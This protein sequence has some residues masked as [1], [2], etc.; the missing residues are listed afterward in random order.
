MKLGESQNKKKITPWDVKSSKIILEDRWIKVRVDE[1]VTSS[2]IVISPYYVLEYP[3]WV[4]MV[5]VDDKKQVLIT[6]QYRHGLK[7]ASFELPCGTQEKKDKN[8]LEAAKRELLEE[9]GFIGNFIL[10][11]QVSPNPATHTNIIYTFLVTNPVRKIQPHD[12][13]SEVLNFK[14]IN[15]NQVFELIDKGEF[16]QALHISSLILGLRKQHQN[17]QTMI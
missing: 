1:C 8:P 2:G 16:Q 9:A 3:D 12:D 10:A 4:H 14:F 15:I 13:P 5:V 7:R 17:I 6:E 11:G